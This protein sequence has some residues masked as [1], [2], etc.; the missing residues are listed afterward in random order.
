ML[1]EIL[2]NVDRCFTARWRGYDRDEVDSAF[3]AMDEEIELVCADRDAAL[4]TAQDMSRQL[5]ALRSEVAEYR[6]MH[7]GYSKGSPVAGCMP[8]LIHLAKLS[9]LAIE[10][11]ARKQA[12]ALVRR[13]EDMMVS[14]A[15]LLDEAE[16][17]SQRM[18][19]NAA[20]Q[21]EKI[22]EDAKVETGGRLVDATDHFGP[23]AR[24]GNHAVAVDIPAPRQSRATSPRHALRPDRAVAG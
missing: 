15:V 5:E 7:A 1:D 10:A 6:L 8:Y 4:S 9:A 22:I 17:E 23:A 12:D 21:A 14:G 19:S 18:L 24:T 2:Q 3:A 11:E 13:A 16:Q 20:R